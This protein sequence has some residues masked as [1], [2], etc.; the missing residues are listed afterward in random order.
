MRGLSVILRIIGAALI[1]WGIYDFYHWGTTGKALLQYYAGA[2]AIEKLVG[3]SFAG[4]LL[5]TILG[6]LITSVSFILLKR[7]KK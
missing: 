6:A 4:G 7:E 5:K 3:Y 1:L 2:A